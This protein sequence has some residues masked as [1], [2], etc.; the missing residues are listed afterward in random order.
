MKNLVFILSIFL[1]ILNSCQFPL[2][3][4]EEENFLKY[5]TVGQKIK[6]TKITGL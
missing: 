2:N 5:L 3:S 1:L 6:Y 4:E